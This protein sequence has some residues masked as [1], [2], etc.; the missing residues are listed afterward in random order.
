MPTLQHRVVVPANSQGK[1]VTRIRTSSSSQEPCRSNA[2]A[3]VVLQQAQGAATTVRRFSLV[4]QTSQAPDTPRNGTVAVLAC[5]DGTQRTNMQVASRTGVVTAQRK[6]S[7][8]SV[9]SQ[10]PN[11]TR[12]SVVMPSSGLE[13]SKRNSIALSGA[14]QQPPSTTQDNGIG[15]SVAAPAGANVAVSMGQ[16]AGQKP[17]RSPDTIITWLQQ[18]PPSVLPGAMQEALAA[19]VQSEGIDGDSFTK[20]V[21]DAAS[22]SSRGV[23][24]PVR[25]MKLRKA[26]GEVLREDECGRIAAEALERNSNMSKAVRLDLK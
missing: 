11:T 12:F 19:A 20:I 5:S 9:A 10:L 25:A 17:S 24:S 2:V 8:S 15:F 7:I 1:D 23:P 18:L 6:E 4:S 22:L 3:P 21:E 26:W 14:P 16:V 13:T